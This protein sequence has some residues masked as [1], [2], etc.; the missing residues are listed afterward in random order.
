MALPEF[1]FIHATDLKH[2]VNLLDKYGDEAKVAGGTTVFLTMA[3]QGLILCPYVV[4]ISKL[5]ELKYIKKENGQ[6]CIG[7]L[8]THRDIEK[9]EI[10]QKGSMSIL[11]QME[12]DVASV[13]IRNRGTIGGNLAYAEPNCDPPPVL[14]ALNANIEIS[15][16]TG[17]RMVPISSFYKGLYY[18]DVNA[19]EIIT[20]IVMPILPENYRGYYYKFTQRKGMDKPFI[21]VAAVLCVENN[22]FKDVR[23]AIGSMAEK[24]FRAVKA[25]ESLVGKKVSSAVIE[26]AGK[27]AAEGVECLPDLRCSEEYKVKVLPVIVKRAIN[28]AVEAYKK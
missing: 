4:G 10:L 21:G 7:A 3:R 14:L 17:K 24:P 12:A 28:K 20:K 19:N 11:S 18:P 15:S 23:I 27:L 9:S 13:Q 26:Q 1:N 2:A 16:A 22:I 25:E 8:T 5:K 6:L